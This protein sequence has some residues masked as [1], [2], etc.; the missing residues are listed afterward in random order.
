MNISEFWSSG[1]INNLRTT[2]WSLAQM[3]SDF[4]SL[5]WTSNQQKV[6]TDKLDFMFLSSSNRMLMNT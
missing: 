1:I 4:S 5:T 3:G 6:Y 2:E